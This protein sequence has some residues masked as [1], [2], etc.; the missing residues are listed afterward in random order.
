MMKIKTEKQFRE[1]QDG[2]EALIRRGA[3]LGG[4]DYLSDEEKCEYIRLSDA[5]IE[6]EAAYYPL[7]GR[8]STLTKRTMTAAE[9]VPV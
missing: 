3:E 1:Y 8:A 2:C 5:V 6:Y 9:R 4:M 7:P